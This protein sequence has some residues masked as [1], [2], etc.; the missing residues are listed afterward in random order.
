[1]EPSASLSTVPSVTDADNLRIKLDA[2]FELGRQSRNCNILLK[3]GKY[4]LRNT[5]KGF[6]LEVSG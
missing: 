2:R 4:K 1:M 5:K 6:L 3:E